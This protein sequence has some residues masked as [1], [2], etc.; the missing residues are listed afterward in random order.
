MSAIY[1]Y[2]L[3]LFMIVC[4]AGLVIAYGT[5][6]RAGYKA[7]SDQSDRDHRRQ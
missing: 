7:G 4:V 6:F 5:G 3:L 2:L 1:G